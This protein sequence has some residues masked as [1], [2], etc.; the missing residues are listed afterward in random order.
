MS[1]LDR[2]PGPWLG[3]IVR[4]ALIIVGVS[5]FLPLLLAKVPLLSYLGGAFDAWFVF[6]CHRE[7]AR[8]FFVFG[9]QL[10]VCS[11]CFGIY[12]GLGL[13][14]L[15]LRPRLS[16]W[17]LRIWVG[18]AVVAMLLDVG[19]ELLNMRPENA[20]LRL[21]TGLALAYPVGSALVWSARGEPEER[22]E[23]VAA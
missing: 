5:P 21:V 7:A 19:T 6:Q 17:P 22:R 1:A 10:P 8:S 4:A 14:A 15:L 13:G 20:W 18:L 3:R 11:R 2:L 23:D 16:T 9:H 12:A